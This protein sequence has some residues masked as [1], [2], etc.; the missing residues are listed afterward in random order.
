MSFKLKRE[1]IPEELPDLTSRLFGLGEKINVMT[2]QP[3]RP[4]FEVCAELKE[5]LNQLHEINQ[6][7]GV[8]FKFYRWPGYEFQVPGEN[9]KPNLAIFIYRLTKKCTG[10]ELVEL[11][12]LLNENYFCG[13]NNLLCAVYDNAKYQFPQLRN[14]IE[15]H[16]MDAPMYVDRKLK[17]F[18]PMTPFLT[19][20]GVRTIVA[21]KWEKHNQ[22]T[23]IT[24]PKVTTLV[25][26][27]TLL[28]EF[29]LSLQSKALFILNFK[30]DVDAIHYL[31]LVVEKEG[32]KISILIADSIYPF[33]V[34]FTEMVVNQLQ[35]LSFNTTI[36][37]VEDLRQYD[38]YSCPVFSISDVS[39]I[40]KVIEQ[41]KTSFFDCFR[42]HAEIVQDS[43]AESTVQKVK[44]LP[45][46]MMKMTQSLT[47][48]KE[49]S[50]K[51]PFFSVRGKGRKINIGEY[52][53]GESYFIFDLESQTHKLVNYSAT[54]KSAKYF[55][56]ILEQVVSL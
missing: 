20:L 10:K 51:A 48:I 37:V 17:D 21:K 3:E 8:P 31:S 47:K 42:K 46:N 39:G 40:S 26:I 30:N 44:K 45:L 4:F 14:F 38:M 25:E 1:V 19:M 43:M 56:R 16:H 50:E 9:E 6:R 5:I 53:A 49:L 52:V 13:T 24:I 11:V 7:S 15:L 23:S 28:Q 12:S 32:D 2:T 54:R 33:R 34:E 29:A 27:R 35:K 36:Y 55:Q 22:D 18:R 41:E